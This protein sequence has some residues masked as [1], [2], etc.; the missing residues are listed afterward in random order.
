MDLCRHPPGEKGTRTHGPRENSRK[1]RMHDLGVG[2]KDGERWT[3]GSFRCRCQVAVTW[4]RHPLDLLRPPDPARS[5]PI[6]SPYIF[7]FSQTVYRKR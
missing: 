1:H 2:Q 3:H 6:M 4:M 7:S 5:A